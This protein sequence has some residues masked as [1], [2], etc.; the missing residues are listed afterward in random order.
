M[1]SS[2]SLENCYSN[3]HDSSNSKGPIQTSICTQ[4]LLFIISSKYWSINWMQLKGLVLHDLDNEGRDWKERVYKMFSEMRCNLRYNEIQ[5][6][7]TLVR[8][9]V[10]FLFLYPSYGRWFLTVPATWPLIKWYSLVIYNLAP[11]QKKKKKNVYA[12][13]PR[14]RTAIINYCN[15]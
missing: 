5:W 12:H 10:R 1:S 11:P 2:A 13:D 3:L 14:L 7:S 9:W 4:V 8:Y 15:F 6:F